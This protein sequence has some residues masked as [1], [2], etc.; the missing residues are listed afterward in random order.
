MEDD[1]SSLAQDVVRINRIQQIRQDSIRPLDLIFL[2][3]LNKASIVNQ[4]VNF[5]Q[6]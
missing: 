4:N 3:N 5:E 1:P 6:S 2:T